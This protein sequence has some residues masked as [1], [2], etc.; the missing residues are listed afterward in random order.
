VLVKQK[1]T[2]AHLKGPSKQRRMA[3]SPLEHPLLALEIFMFLY[4]T[5]EEKDDV[6]GG[7]SKTAQHPIEK[8][9]RNI[10][11]VFLK[12]G[13]R[14]AHHKRDRMTLTMLLPRQHSWLQS[15]SIKKP[16]I[17]ICN[18]LKWYRGSCSEHTWFPYCLTSPH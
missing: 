11:A 5:N 7:S 8:N 2:P 9:S 4:C 14:N 1:I 18:L 17:P 13:T 12:P 16:S 15:L 6:I 10:K 3:F